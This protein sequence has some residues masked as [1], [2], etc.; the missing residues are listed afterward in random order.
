[1]LS[2]TFGG[3]VGI[4]DGEPMSRGPNGRRGGWEL[5][6]PSDPLDERSEVCPADPTIGLPGPY[7]SEGGDALSL[8][9][10]CASISSGGLENLC[11]C[12]FWSGIL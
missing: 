7:W 8:A 10:R 5:Y 11:K 4:L 2:G 9:K 12:A 6:V 3:M 1:M